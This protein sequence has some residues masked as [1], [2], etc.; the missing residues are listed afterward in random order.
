M[1]IFLNNR[2]KDIEEINYKDEEEN[3]DKD[4]LGTH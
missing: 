4:G 2:K 1:E 3:I